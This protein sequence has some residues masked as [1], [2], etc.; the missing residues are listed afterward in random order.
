[1]RQEGSLQ[2]KKILLTGG[3]AATTAISVVEEFIRENAA[4]S[5]SSN[6]KKYRWDIYWV[7]SK[8]AIEGRKVPTLEF[9]TLPK[10]GVKH[11]SIA[12]GRLQRKFSIWTIPS[13]AKIPLGFVSAAILVRKIKPDVILSFGGFA[14]F[15]VVFV[16]YL[17]GIPIIIHEQTAVCGRANKL[18]SYFATKIALARAT[19]INFFQKEKCV[20]VGN[21]IMTQIRE[22]SPKEKIGAPPTLYVTGGSRG[23][24]KINNLVEE[25]LEPLLDEF[26]L[27]HQVGYIDYDKFEKRKSELPDNLKEKYEIYDT[28]DPLQLDGV[29]KRADI[30]VARA[31]ANTVAEIIAVKRPAIL[32]PLPF[33]YLNEQTKNALFAQKYKIVKILNQEGLKGITLLKEIKSLKKN[34]YDLVGKIARFKSPDID[35][36]HKLV[37][38]VKDVLR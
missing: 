6:E 11:F 36:S 38:I 29:Y 5:P 9:K 22:I 23:A 8:Y 2:P 30:I 14:A 12:A 18:S 32:I 13:L 26:L 1:M 25:I 33:S 19:S 37:Q 4:F 27:I 16:G 7:G 15:P 20:V 10:F 3:H 21:P 35:A 17:F 24:Q 34:W 31:G 28:I